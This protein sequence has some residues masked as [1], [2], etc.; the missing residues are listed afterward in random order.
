MSIDIFLSK[1]LSNFYK[2]II[3]RI[4]WSSIWSEKPDWL[5][6]DNAVKYFRNVRIDGEDL[7]VTIASTDITCL[8]SHFQSNNEY[9]QLIK[10]YVG[11]KYQQLV[12]LRNVSDDNT[13]SLVLEIKDAIL[14][15]LKPK[16]ICNYETWPYITKGFLE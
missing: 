7:V 8:Q 12:A 2:M 16:I 1:G 5:T 3:K 4:P 11:Y 9:Y 6:D 13:L 15:F 14:N 10:P